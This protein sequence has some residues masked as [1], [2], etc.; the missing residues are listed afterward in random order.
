M[1]LSDPVA[2]MLTRIRNGCQAE[3]LEVAMPTSKLK[4]GIADILKQ[5]GFII[6]WRVE[7][8]KKKDL[9]VALKYFEDEPVIEGLQRVSKPSQR[10]YVG[11]GEIPRVLGGLGVAI[12]STSNG[13]LAGRQAREQNIG[14]EV[15]CYV[16]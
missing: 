6:D 4:E 14:G 13:V 11:S 2:D 15:L 3:K 9:I 8:E 7:G 10:R 1:S 16:W 12:L 5:N